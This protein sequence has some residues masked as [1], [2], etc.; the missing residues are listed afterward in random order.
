[1]ATHDSSK[2]V[3]LHTSDHSASAS[4]NTDRSE[5]WKLFIHSMVADG[6]QSFCCRKEESRTCAQLRARARF[7]HCMYATSAHAAC[8][9]AELLGRHFNKSSV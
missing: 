1:M 4:T 5:C 3:R 8:R 6:S 7:Q 2:F 9:C